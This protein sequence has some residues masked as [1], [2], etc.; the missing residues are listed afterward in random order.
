MLLIF[1]KVLASTGRS[2]KANLTEPATPPPK[3]CRKSGGSTQ[4]QPFGRGRI[5]RIETVSG[6]K[7]TTP[8]QGA[9][10][11]DKTFCEHQSGSVV[12]PQ[13][14]QSSRTFPPTEDHQNSNANSS[15]GEALPKLSCDNHLQPCGCRVCVVYISCRKV[16]HAANRCC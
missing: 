1:C 13:V 15:N 3:W 9:A 10:H 5:S 14:F 8:V 11:L 6:V 2:H 7:T 16:E 4:D 12:D